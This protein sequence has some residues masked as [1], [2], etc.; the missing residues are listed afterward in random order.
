MEKI[1]VKQVRGQLLPSRVY[2]GEMVKALRERLGL[3]QEQFA[4]YLNASVYLVRKIE[5]R[6]RLNVSAVN[7]A[8]LSRLARNRKAPPAPT[9]QVLTGADVMALRK[10]LNL[11]QPVL[12]A[13]V[14]ASLSLVKKWE[15][16]GADVVLTGGY[17][18]LVAELLQSGLEAFLRGT[19]EG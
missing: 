16:L 18:L 2:N 15:R 17:T 1:S 11:S 8:V 3:T 13:L 9:A 6:P 19:D 10:Q 12:G 5:H 4:P 7:S 14:G